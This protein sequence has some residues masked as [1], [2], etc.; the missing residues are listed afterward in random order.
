MAAAEAIDPTELPYGKRQYYAARAAA[1]SASP[2]IAGVVESVSHAEQAAIEAAGYGDAEGWARTFGSAARANLLRCIFGNPFPFSLWL[3]HAILSWNDCTVLRIAEGVYDE[4]VF[5]R[6]PILAD[7]LLD[8]DC[9]DEELI[10]HCRS[11]GPHVRG[12]WA[13]DLILG[14]S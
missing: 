11:A 3:S 13:V 10:A 4:E 8:A 2:E 5:D 1:E 12:C 9:D 6:L 14:K 7:A